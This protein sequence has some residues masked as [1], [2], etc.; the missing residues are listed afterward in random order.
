MSLT[1]IHS[2][3][4]SGG[5][6][7]PRRGNV[8]ANSVGVRQ[9]SWE[10]GREL[11]SS[12]RQIAKATRARRKAPRCGYFARHDWP[13]RPVP[14]RVASGRADRGGSNR[15]FRGERYPDRFVRRNGHRDRETRAVTEPLASKSSENT[16]FRGSCIPAAWA[17]RRLRR[18]L[19]RPVPKAFRPVPSM[20]SSR[21]WACRACPTARFSGARCPPL[22]GDC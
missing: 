8:F 4:R 20:T 16:Y 3:V 15:R 2:E 17:R 5:W 13:R 22:R 9:A 10:C 14:D 1:F 11:L 12:S 19:W 21:A 18:S 7:F 6:I